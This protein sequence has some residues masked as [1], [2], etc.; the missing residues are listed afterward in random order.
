MIQLAEP[1]AEA[2]ATTALPFGLIAHP[3]ANIFPMLTPADLAELAADIKANGQREAVILHPDGR[4]LDGR[5]RLCACHEAGVQP[6]FTTWTGTDSPVTAV[7]SLNLFRRHLTPSQKALVAAQ[8][9]AMFETEAAARMRAG[10][11]AATPKE[12][13]KG[14][15]RSSEEA[16]ALVGVSARLVDDAVKVLREGVPELAAAVDAGEVSVSAAAAV[17]TLPHEEQRQVLAVGPGAVIDR[18]KIVR[19]AHSAAFDTP[20]NALSNFLGSCPAPP[21]FTDED[22]VAALSD[23]LWKLGS[24]QRHARALCWFFSRL[25]QAATA[26]NPTPSTE[27]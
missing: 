25:S 10:K 12:G 21:K 6:R 18:A 9:K 2:V 20:W 19:A 8:A 5:N 15:R 22:L 27:G 11:R 13:G 1:A 17:A 7:M 24:T 23:D 4:V 3:A 26:C 16:A 14:R